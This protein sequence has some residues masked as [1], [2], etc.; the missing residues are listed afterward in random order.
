MP[1]HATERCKVAVIGGGILGCSIAYHLAKLGITDV[2]VLERNAIASGATGRAAALLTKVRSKPHQIPLVQRT[3][4]AIRELQAFQGDDLRLRRTGSLHV[5][6][7]RNRLEELGRLAAQAAEFG[8]A[9]RWMRAEEAERLVPW[10]NAREACGL[11]LMPEDAFIDPYLLTGSYMQAARAMGVVFRQGVAVVG[12][13]AGEGRVRG[14]L[15]PDGAIESEWVVNAA[16]A[17]ANLLAVDHGVL[18]PLSPVRSHYW[19]AAPP[20]AQPA[21][22]PYVV[23]PDAGAYVR[24]DQGGLIIGLR[25]SASLSLDPRALP[26][27]L[28][29]REFGTE[30]EGWDILIEKSAHLRRCYPAL[31]QTGFR[32]FVTGLSTYT[33]DGEFVIGRT[34]L[35]GYLVAS[36]C[37]G[38]GIAASGG[39]GL[40]IADLVAGGTPRVNLDP[41]RPDRLGA[42]DPFSED[43]RGHC[44]STRS[45]KASG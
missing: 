2:R 36:G 40:G 1:G 16:G 14:V 32:R 11:L 43:F 30:A 10:L 33:P 37:C 31:D 3:Y 9:S 39:I 6:L 26:D 34:L 23:L 44:A 38:A 42:I 41:Y 17:W 12:L 45:A 28:T 24:P 13:V 25:E 18:L 22:M 7:S 20:G 19:I 21:T 29:G 15:T 5:A 27:D 4:A 35:E 8:L